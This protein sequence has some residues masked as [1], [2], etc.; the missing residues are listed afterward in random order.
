VPAHPEP[1][2]MV[3]PVILTMSDALR[4]IRRGTICD[5]KTI[6]GL[7]FVRD[8]LHRRRRVAS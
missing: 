5:A 1:D 3:T 6:I 4:R 2:E 8:R 7:L